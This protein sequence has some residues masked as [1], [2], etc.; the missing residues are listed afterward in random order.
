MRILL[1]PLLFLGACAA[2][3]PVASLSR[4]PEDSTQVCYA[5]C[6]RIGVKLSAVVVVAG[7]V[8]CVCEVTPGGNKGAG[9]AAASAAAVII[10]ANAAA[11]TQQAQQAA[12]HP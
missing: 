3:P 10:A 6:E 2:A 1:I 7:A 9:G 12:H 8:G 11:A 4:L 5:V